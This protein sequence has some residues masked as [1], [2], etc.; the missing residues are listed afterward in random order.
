[1]ELHS[2][3]DASDKW[4]VRPWHGKQRLFSF[5]EHI[6]YI[7]ARLGM[8]SDVGHCPWAEQAPGVHHL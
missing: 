6:N 3:V 4:T 8:F 2:P 1:M 7:A 5:R